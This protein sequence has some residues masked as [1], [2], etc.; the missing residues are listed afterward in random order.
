M[1][2]ITPIAEKAGFNAAVGVMLPL[3]HFGRVWKDPNGDSCMW[4]VTLLEPD[5]N[6]PVGNGIAGSVADATSAI[7]TFVQCWIAAGHNVVDVRQRY[8]IPEF[9]IDTMGFTA[10][11]NR[12]QSG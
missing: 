2:D 4:Q 11:N 12:R 10:A 3:D 7:F 6:T 8:Q 9:T 5:R 1:P